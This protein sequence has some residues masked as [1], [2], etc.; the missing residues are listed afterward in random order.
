MDAPTR[1]NLKYTCNMAGIK[2][3]SWGLEDFLCVS[4]EHDITVIIH[5]LH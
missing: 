3:V 4:S 5:K 2:L 1:L